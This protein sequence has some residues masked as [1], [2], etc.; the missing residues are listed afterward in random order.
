MRFWLDN[1]PKDA[2]AVNISNAHYFLGL[3]HEQRGRRDQ[4]KTEYQAAVAANPKH[5]DAKKALSAVK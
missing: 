3:V 2:A 5:D 4:A 1:Q